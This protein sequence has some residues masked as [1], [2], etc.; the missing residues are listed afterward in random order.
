MSRDLLRVGVS[1]SLAPYA[2]GFASEL[3]G[4]GYLA[5]AAKGQL[6]LMAHLSRW[7]ACEGVDAT[8]LDEAVV[9]QFLAARRGQGYTRL[10]SRRALVPLMAF[11]RGLGVVALPAPV[12]AQ[13][14][15]DVVLERYSGYLLVERG[16]GAGTVRGY[17]EKVRPFIEGRV[18]ADGLDLEGLTAADV[19]A[20]ALAV[21]PLHSVSTA[22]LTMTALRS[23]LGFL[24]L[25][26]TLEFS[27]AGAAPAA[28]GWHL[29]G[30]PRRLES[31]EVSRLLASCDRRSAT[32]RRDFAILLLLARLGLRRGEV[33]GLRLEH[34][35]WRAGEIAVAG[36]G[37]RLER[38]PLPDDVGEA[39]AGYLRHGRPS[40]IAC[41]AVFI[42]A[43]VLGRPWRR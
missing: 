40:T 12:V 3:I 21:C 8:A 27:L 18:T 20:F 34:L 43:I 38:L 19:S 14:A 33:A 25:E 9:E 29:A 31:G 4:Q 11:L 10:R 13:T 1:G 28:A 24:H 37:D 41:R 26:G 30:L 17:L 2:A 32:G 6:R 16:L 39:V 15:V 7:L 35:Y 23:L 42:R 36:K 5:T 22:K